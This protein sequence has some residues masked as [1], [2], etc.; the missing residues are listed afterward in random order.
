MLSFQPKNKPFSILVSYTPTVLNTV[1]TKAREDDDEASDP[2]IIT[3]DRPATQEDGLLTLLGFQTSQ[4]SEAHTLNA[5]RD[6][7]C[8]LGEVP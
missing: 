6:H 4:D 2:E 1:P 3:N 5:Y 7:S 8:P